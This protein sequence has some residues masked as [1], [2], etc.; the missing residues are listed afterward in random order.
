MRDPLLTLEKGHVWLMRLDRRGPFSSPCPGEEFSLLLVTGWGAITPT[1]QNELST[2]FVRQGCRYAMCAGPQGSSW[3]DSID[4]V[5][6]DD[7][8]RGS[9]SPFTM[10]TWHDDETLEDTAEFFANCSFFDDWI[11]EN[12]VVCVLDGSEERLAEVRSAVLGAFP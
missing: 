5:C 10:T 7:E 11:A 2:A 8:L 1:Q 6:V 4:W 9:P 12:F 3:D